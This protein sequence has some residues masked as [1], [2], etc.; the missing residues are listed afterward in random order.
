MNSISTVKNSDTLWLGE[1]RFELVF[2]S[3]T[4]LFTVLSYEASRWVPIKTSYLADSVSYLNHRIYWILRFSYG[5]CLSSGGF[6]WW[7]FPS[8]GSKFLLPDRDLFRK[9]SF[10]GIYLE[11]YFSPNSLA[12]LWIMSCMTIRTSESEYIKVV[13]F[14]PRFV[15][16]YP[17][18]KLTRLF[19]NVNLGTLKLA[20]SFIGRF[21]SA[22]NSECPGVYYCVLKFFATFW[23]WGYSR[24]CYNEIDLFTQ[25]L[26]FEFWFHE[27]ILEFFPW[28][29]FIYPNRWNSKFWFLFKIDPW[30]FSFRVFLTLQGLR[31]LELS[32]H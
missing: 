13:Q 15:L 21:H 17:M 20:M 6:V 29:W 32:Y 12:A 28:D 7:I 23:Q 24:I 16:H 25:E 19:S 18:E 30:I 1:Y 26:K 5:C 31:R 22:M 2:K 8:R 27:N 9:F 3:E 11:E 4:V 14:C 10:L